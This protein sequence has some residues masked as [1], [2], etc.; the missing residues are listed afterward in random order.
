MT[1]N[2]RIPKHI[3]ALSTFNLHTAS[4]EMKCQLLLILSYRIL[5]E[6]LLYIWYIKYRE[7]S[8]DNAN[9]RIHVRPGESPI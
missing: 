1:Y 2:L 8:G 4:S 3:L 6:F 7:S 5:R 9:E